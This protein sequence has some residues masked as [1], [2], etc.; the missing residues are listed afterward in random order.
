MKINEEK[1]PV[2]H[3]FIGPDTTFGIANNAKAFDILSSKIYTDV[4][5]AIVRELSTNAYDSHVMA[6][7]KDVP[8]QVHLPNYED[9]YFSIRDFGTGLSHEDMMGLYTSYFTS[10]R[11]DSNDTIGCL[12]LGSKSPFA[13][14]SQ[15]SVISFFNGTKSV[16]A[17]FKNEDGIPS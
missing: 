2:K 6:N 13:Y 10:N 1:S 11:S 5:L 3:N 14:T 15:F 17:V 12:G 8:F 16:Y 9:S 4:P 7:R